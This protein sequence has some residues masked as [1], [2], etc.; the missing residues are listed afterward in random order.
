MARS[1]LKATISPS[2]VR[3]ENI[4]VVK[5]GVDQVSSEGRAEREKER[6]RERGGRRGTVSAR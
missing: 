4:I 1:R 2:T 6:G 5:T 3:E